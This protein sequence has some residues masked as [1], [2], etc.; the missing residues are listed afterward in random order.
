MG[1]AARAGVTIVEP[2]L[3][4]PGPRGE[5]LAD[6]AA[7]PT[8]SWSTRPARAPAPGGAIPRRAGGSTPERLERLCEA[9]AYLLDLAAELVRPG[10]RIVYAVCSLLAEEGRDQAAALRRPFSP[11]SGRPPPSRRTGR[12]PGRMLTPAMTARTAFSSRGGGRHA[13]L[14]GDRIM[15]ILMRLTPIALTAA[16]ALATMASAGQGQKPD[17]QIDRALGRAR[18]A[19]A[20]ADSA[21]ARY[22]EATDLLETALAVDPRNRQAYIGLARARRGRSCPARRSNSISRR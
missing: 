22:Q 15:E 16:I 11:G 5:A 14:A 12:R 9:Q 19:G 17:D 3:L 13:R 18:P 7:R 8:S 10:G 21:Q 1:P 6:L 20:G 4:D 2:R